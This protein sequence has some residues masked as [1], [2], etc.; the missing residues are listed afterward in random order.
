M[1][2]TGIILS[3]KVKIIKINS[4]FIDQKTIL[5]ISIKD[6]IKCFEKYDHKKYTIGWIDTSSKNVETNY[7]FSKIIVKINL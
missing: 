6:L 7:F 4:T 5:P 2:L 1:G 3:A